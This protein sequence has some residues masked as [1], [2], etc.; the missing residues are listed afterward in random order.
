[1]RSC[2]CRQSVLVGRPRQRGFTLIE[3][4]IVMVILGLL[5]SLIAPQLFDKVGAS[6][7]QVAKTQIDMLATAVDSYILDVGR[8]PQSLN[9]LIR[10]DARGWRGPYLRDNI[11]K[12]PWGNDYIQRTGSGGVLYEIM[13]LGADG[14]P[15]G[16]GD[17]ADISRRG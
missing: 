15:G 7:V 12:D 17:N 4:L 6:K 10:S 9:E 8:V 3:L 14:E 13:S 5:A 16:E 11:P 1:M 2:V